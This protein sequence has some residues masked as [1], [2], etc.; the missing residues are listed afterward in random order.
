MSPETQDSDFT[1][2]LEHASHGMEGVVTEFFPRVVFDSS[3]FTIVQNAVGALGVMGIPVVWV[4]LSPGVVCSILDLGLE[5]E[6]R[7]VR[8]ACTLDEGLALL[9]RDLRKKQ[10]WSV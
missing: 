3:V 1:A 4:G 8:S 7:A 6:L 5:S 10:R 9:E 2:V